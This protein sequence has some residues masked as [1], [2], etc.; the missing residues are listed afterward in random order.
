MA[1]IMLIAQAPGEVEDSLGKMFIGPSG[2]VLDAV[3]KAAGIRRKDIY[4]TNLL[5]CM[6]PKNRRPKQAEIQSCAPFL[7]QEIKRVQPLVISPLGYYPTKY[8]FERFKLENFSKSEYPQTIAKIRHVDDVMIYPLTHPTSIIH[9]KEF[10][11]GSVQ[12]YARLIEMVQCKW[13]PVCPIKR[14]TDSGELNGKWVRKY[15]KGNWQNC[16]RYQL[17]EAGIP[18]AD[19][20]LPD[21]STISMRDSRTPG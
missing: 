9:H 15:C 12:N 21:G 2:K 16:V 3:L 13:Y 19:E 20:L 7:E 4:I 6:L 1:K 14:F 10:F 8:I 5:K 18:H 11:V 17:E